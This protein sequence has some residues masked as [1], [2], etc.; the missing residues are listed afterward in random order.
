[1]ATAALLGALTCSLATRW[2]LSLSRGERS[3]AIR[4][5]SHHS[6]R[7]PTPRFGGAGLVAAFIIVEVYI[8]L[9]DRGQSGAI[10][11]PPCALI[12]S[13]AMFGLGLW[14]DYKPLGPKRK[15]AGQV[16]ICSAL[17]RFGLGVQSLKLP[18]SG[19]IV[20]LGVWG[21]PLTVL[22]LVGMTN[23][24]NFIDGT[25]G[26]AAGVSFILMVLLG[27]I[28]YETG[29]FELEASGLA[30][31][32]LGFLYYNLPP[33]RIYMG[34]GGA[35]FLGFQIGLLALLNSHKGEVC[36]ALAAP[37]LVLTLPIL[38]TVLSIARRVLQG[39]PICR[40]DRCH[41]HHRLLRTGLSRGQVLVIFYGLTL[42]FL[43]LGLGL[44]RAHAPWEAA[45]LG[46]IALIMVGRAGG[47]SLRWNWV[48]L[49]QR[50]ATAWRM[51]RHVRYALGLARLLEVEG[52][53][54]ASID[55]LWPELVSM[56]ARL[57]FVSLRLTLADGARHW[58]KPGFNGSALDVGIDIPDPRFG[59]MELAASPQ[60]VKARA[61]GSDTCRFQILGELLVQG[62]MSA[63]TPYLADSYC[64]LAFSSQNHQLPGRSKRQRLKP[65]FPQDLPG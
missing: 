43:L 62:W 21:V 4:G 24:I 11:L 40:A 35:Y 25:D 14:D 15:L 53:R 61:S 9:A 34:D 47:F 37:M 19:E 48:D 58:G 45:L 29:S 38:D 10:A 18:V 55:E 36:T 3:W 20:G 33:A 2:I 52:R 12:S 23:L 13:L 60:S 17:C 16:I 7:A 57:G 5:E 63:T 27:Y 50:I 64:G 6:H 41:L 30:G 65:R 56:A 32:L 46:A 22:W 1:M 39:L 26:L 31:A 49:R 59:T 42:I 51:R 8:G 28:G 54:R 44:C